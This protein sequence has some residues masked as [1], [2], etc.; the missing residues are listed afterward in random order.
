[1]RGAAQITGAALMAAVLMTGCSNG[2]DGKK[3]DGQKDDR[4]DV[5]PTRVTQ[6]SGGAA[7]SKRRGSSREGVFLARTPE[8]PVALSMAAGK[9]A[10][11]SDGGKRTCTGSVDG[12]SL[13][14]KCTDNDTRRTVG[15]IEKSDATSMVV[16]WEGGP[17]ETFV[18]RGDG[19]PVPGGPKGLPKAG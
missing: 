18:R 14:L 2:G 1:M 19:G 15:L 8:G 7:E 4:A 12:T 6:Q 17:K 5:Q 11:V 9:A 13:M 3:G 10:L 16:S